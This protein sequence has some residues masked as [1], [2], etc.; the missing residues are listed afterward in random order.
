[1]HW[2]EGPN[3]RFQ[4]DFVDHHFIDRD[5]GY[6]YFDNSHGYQSHYLFSD[7]R[8]NRD[9]HHCDLGTIW[10]FAIDESTALVL[11]RQ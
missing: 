11:I 6:F 2:R 9:H 3:C 4:R 7:N 10:Q 5:H 8:D 1:M